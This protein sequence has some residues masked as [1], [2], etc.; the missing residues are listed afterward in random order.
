MKEG[1]LAG[2][3]A[4]STAIS[5]VG[6]EGVGLTYR[7]YSIEDLAERATFEEVA[8]LLIRGDLPGREELN[9]YREVLRERRW[10]PEE[11]KR[12]LEQIPKEAHPME[13][14]RTGCSALGTLEPEE[15]SNLFMVANRLIACLPSMLLYW[16]QFHRTGQRLDTATEE[17]SVAGHFLRLLQGESADD[18]VER[19]LDV[20]LILYAEH[21]FNAST[22]TARIVASTL[23]DVYSAVTAGIGALRGPLHGG[24]NEAAME[25]IEQFDT[26]E[27]AEAGVMRMLAGKEKI[28]GFGHRIYRS[29]DPRSDVIKRW[30][31]RLGE[32][33]GDLRLYEVSERIEEVM[34]RE[35]GLFPNLDFYSASVYRACG[36]PTPLFTPIFVLARV[37]GWMAHIFEQRCDNRLIRP[38]AHYIGLAAKAFLPLDERDDLEEEV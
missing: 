9:R 35:K 30:S 20:S 15:R 2:V 23:S 14:L 7:G 6:K 36:I 5:T 33:G 31:K 18:L 32:A 19:A 17:P 25:L 21:E 11:L 29:A 24:A 10:L 12:I 37:A 4:G 34:R 38:T 28:M 3:V 22:F 26:P 27:A 8:C 13:V 16:Y 1:G